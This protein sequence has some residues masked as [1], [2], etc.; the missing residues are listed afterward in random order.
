MTQYSTVYSRVYSRVYLTLM[1]QLFKALKLHQHSFRM[2]TFSNEFVFLTHFCVVLAFSLWVWACSRG[3]FVLDV[4]RRE[5]SD[6]HVVIVHKLV[7]SV[8][9]LFCSSLLFPFLACV[10]NSGKPFVGEIQH[11][12]HYQPFGHS[13]F[14]PFSF[15]RPLKSSEF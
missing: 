3:L 4:S 6:V 15:T 7:L 1:K 8:R 10:W 14:S 12:Y 13:S 2:Q 11:A 5:G 9:T